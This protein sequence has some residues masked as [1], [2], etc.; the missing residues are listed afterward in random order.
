MAYINLNNYQLNGFLTKKGREFFFKK[1]FN[2]AQFGLGD[3]DINYLTLLNDGIGPDSKAETILRPP[4]TYT[5]GTGNFITLPDI[6]TSYSGNCKI[7]TALIEIKNHILPGECVEKTNELITGEPKISFEYVNITAN[8]LSRGLDLEVI[9]SNLPAPVEFT[10][11]EVSDPNLTFSFPNGNRFIVP[12]G[13]G[14]IVL[15][16]N[17]QTS[18]I[19]SINGQVKPTAYTVEPKLNISLLTQLVFS[20]GNLNLP[21]RRIPTISYQP[22]IILDPV[23]INPNLDLYNGQVKIVNNIIF[24]KAIE[25]ESVF[26]NG[27]LIGNICSNPLP[28]IPGGVATT[29]RP[30]NNPQQIVFNNT[31]TFGLIFRARTANLN[32]RVVEIFNDN[33]NLLINS[34]IIPE[35]TVSYTTPQFII[36]KNDNIRINVRLTQ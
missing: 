12:Q 36:S 34:Y 26:M 13:T 2:I 31:T 18:N 20:S 22:T 25:I 21:T 9:Y 1:G 33:T 8:S 29:F 23:E 32:R 10:I 16:I 15:P 7:N 4:L 24:E 28:L 14:R 19:V 27:I 35:G 5:G 3:S 30:A 6:G 11:T 17:N